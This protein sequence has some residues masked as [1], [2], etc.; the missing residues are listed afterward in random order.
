VKSLHRPIGFR[1]SVPGWVS[2]TMTHRGALT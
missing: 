2:E 1:P